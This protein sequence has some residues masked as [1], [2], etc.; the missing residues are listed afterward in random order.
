MTTKKAVMV[1]DPV[2][3]EKKNKAFARMSAK[4]KRLAIAADV[5]EQVRLKRFTAEQ[6]VYVGIDALRDYKESIVYE[7]AALQ[8]FLVYPPK[9]AVSC[10]VCGIGAIVLSKAK[11]GNEVVLKHRYFHEALEDI[12][13][14]RQQCLI[15]T[16]FEGY[17]SGPYSWSD[18]ENEEANPAAVKFYRKYAGNDDKRL[19]AIF[20]NILK[21]DGEFK[22]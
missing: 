5:I 13:S 9:N 4:R 6:N 14:E 17:N 20:R 18:D 19:V 7:S 10:T 12:F 15:E 11:L 21:N 8:Q 22:P 1:Y 16:A 3:I 2:A